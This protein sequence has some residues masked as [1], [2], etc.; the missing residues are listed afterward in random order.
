MNFE[1]VGSDLIGFINKVCA[2][3]RQGTCK[4]KVMTK[5]RRRL[6][7]MVYQSLARFCH[8]PAR[9]VHNTEVLTPVAT[10]FVTVDTISVNYTIYRLRNIRRVPFSLSHRRVRLVRPELLFWL[11]EDVM[12]VIEE[13]LRVGCWAEKGLLSMIQLLKL[14]FVIK[15]EMTFG[16]VETSRNSYTGW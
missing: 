7:T 15:R 14:V 8:T 16:N 9:D 5:C 1:Y 3:S 11:D 12:R 2:S 10:F 13:K 4:V 6:S